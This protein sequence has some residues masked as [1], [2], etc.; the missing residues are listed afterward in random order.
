MRQ[1]NVGAFYGMP[2]WLVAFLIPAGP[3]AL[4]RVALAA[5]L[6]LHLLGWTTCTA[7]VGFTSCPGTVSPPQISSLT[8]DSISG[9]ASSVLLTVSGRSFSPQ[10]QILWN[11]SALPTTFVD[12]QHLQTTITQQTFDSFGGQADSSVLISVTLPG[13]LALVRCPNGGISATLVLIIS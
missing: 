8:P 3:C 11:G 5:V 9:E 4:V 7:I 12:S 2:G 10:S 13:S 1:A 6:T